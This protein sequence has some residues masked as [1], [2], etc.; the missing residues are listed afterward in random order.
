MT[1][2]DLFRFEV[3]AIGDAIEYLEEHL[4][5]V[6]DSSSIP[7]TGEIPDPESRLWVE[8]IQELLENLKFG[9]VGGRAFMMERQYRKNEASVAE[10]WQ[11][12]CEEYPNYNYA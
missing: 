10:A 11:K 2:E 5:S 1:H 7:N 12:F 8:E 3:A 4:E 9:T 6:I